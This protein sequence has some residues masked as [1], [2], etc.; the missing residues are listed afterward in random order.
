MRNEI[1][2]N[3]CKCLQL[4]EKTW[5]PWMKLCILL[6]LSE[7]ANSVHWRWWPKLCHCIFQGN[8]CLSITTVT[9]S[10]SSYLG[11]LRGSGWC[12]Y[13]ACAITSSHKSPTIEW[14]R[15]NMPSQL[16]Q[17][18]SLFKPKIIFLLLILFFFLLTKKKIL[19]NLQ[20]KSLFLIY[21]YRLY[22]A[23]TVLKEW[24]L[25]TGNNDGRCLN[26]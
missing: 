18:A 20:L 3:N 8:V 11:Q 22:A 23:Q 6:L 26:W 24:S 16:E 2:L 17:K 13:R 19:K 9:T 10:S 21:L 25:V 7:V 1:R 14:T 5:R 4:R 15:K 12:R